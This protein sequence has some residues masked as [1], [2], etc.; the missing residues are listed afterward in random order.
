[1]KKNVDVKLLDVSKGNNRQTKSVTFEKSIG[2]YQS[3]L[4]K[5]PQGIL[6]QNDG[7]QSSKGSILSRAKTNINGNYDGISSNYEQFQANEFGDNFLEED[8]SDKEE[9][10][11][12]KEIKGKPK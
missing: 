10:K 11:A 9:L 2:I 5:K 4:I 12:P 1:M 7:D 8:E 3:V 6:N